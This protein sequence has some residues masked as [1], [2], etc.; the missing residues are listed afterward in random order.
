MNNIEATLNKIFVRNLEGSDLMEIFFVTAVASILAIRGFLHLT[1]YPQLSPG[2]LHIAHVL[3]GGI[4]MLAAMILFQAFTGRAVRSL[5]ALLG[6]FGFGAFIDE[7]GKFVTANNDYFFKPSVAII[8]IIFIIIYFL[9]ERIN[10]APCLSDKER[11]VNVLELTKEAVTQDLR[12]EDQQRAQN[13]LNEADPKNPVTIALSEL[14]KNIESIPTQG[15]DAWTRIKRRASNAYAR[16]VRKT[17]FT[18]AVMALFITISLFSLLINSLEIITR[19]VPE[20]QLPPLTLSDWG[21]TL[22]SLLASTYVAVGIL[23]M[24]SDRLRAYQLFRTSI[25]IQILLVDI[26]IF[27][28]MEFAGLINLAIDLL[29]LLTLRYMIHQ[30]TMVI[31]SASI[32]PMPS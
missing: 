12:S 6:G 1:G 3:V 24:H 23:R 15:P 10:R 19:F 32:Q 13:L 11:L 30:E 26:F 20:L 27:L 22:S 4:F 2:N 16:I 5:A 7:V 8:Y 31:D 9:M 21:G 14:I 28:D 29:V 25:L 17:W 18:R